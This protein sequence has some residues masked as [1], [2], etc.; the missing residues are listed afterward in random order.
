MKILICEN[1]M[2]TARLYKLVLEERGHTV[3]LAYDGKEFLDKY[4][5]EFVKITS[6]VTSIREH[7]Q[8]FDVVLLDYNMPLINGIEIAK[9]VLTVNPHQRIIFASA[10]AKETLFESVKQLKQV[11]ELLQKPFGPDVLIDQM[12]DKEIYSELQS[13]KVDTQALK[14]AALGHEQLKE[15]LATLREI[16]KRRTS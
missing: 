1:D 10:Y 13:L 8:P 11:V 5:R 7:V 12:E 2:D 4:H 6:S 3:E 16:Q 9:E 14:E 15:L